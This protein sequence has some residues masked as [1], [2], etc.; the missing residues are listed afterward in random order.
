M[1]VFDAPP[2]TSHADGLGLAALC[3]RTFV[4]V[5]K[6]RSRRVT[7]QTLRAQLRNVHANVGGA[8]TVQTGRWREV[9][10]DARRSLCAQ[11]AA[12]DRVVGIALDVAYFAIT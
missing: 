6:G 8:L 9:L 12:V 11:H 1:V 2:A 10:P 4:V 3:D 7:L 5:D